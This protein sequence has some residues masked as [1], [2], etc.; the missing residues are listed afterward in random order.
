MTQEEFCLLF[1]DYSLSGI[2]KPYLH[3]GDWAV[4]EILP[5]FLFN[6]SADVRIAT[7]SISEDSL[8]PLFFLSEQNRL[9]SI[10]LLIDT[11]IKRHKLPLL[12]FASGFVP[13]IGT[14][15]VHAKILLIDIDKEHRFGI[16]GSANLN[17]NH[18]WEGGFYFTAGEHFDYFE[19]MFD[20]AFSQ[21]IKE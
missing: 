10:K 16:V 11:T 21:S 2:I 7:Y 15:A 20:V 1:P 6:K 8:R 17:R 3:K 9:R 13:E 18:R 5:V 19:K 12:L 14:D 4:H